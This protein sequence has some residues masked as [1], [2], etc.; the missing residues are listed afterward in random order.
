MFS[1]DKNIVASIYNG[2]SLFTPAPLLCYSHCPLYDTRKRRYVA[3]HLAEQ[4]TAMTRPEV[5]SEL[6]TLPGVRNN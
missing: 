4:Y 2:S 6:K 5:W 1:I 3:L